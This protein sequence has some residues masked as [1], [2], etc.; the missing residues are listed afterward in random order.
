[1][2]TAFMILVLAFVLNGCASNGTGDGPG[3][4][5]AGEANAGAMSIIRMNPEGGLLIFSSAEA[6]SALYGLDSIDG[7]RPGKFPSAPGGGR[8]LPPG[9]HEISFSI[10]SSRARG[11]IKVKLE[12]G[13]GVVYEPRTEIVS[14]AGKVVKFWLVDAATG[15]PVS[16]KEA[17]QLGRKPGDPNYRPE[18]ADWG[19]I[20]SGA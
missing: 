18:D 20:G 9:A 15:Q 1:M 4:T 2:K 6:D 7:K 14:T 16:R 8:L 19:N 3:T 13:P 11:L 17:L 12:A 10:I 5:P